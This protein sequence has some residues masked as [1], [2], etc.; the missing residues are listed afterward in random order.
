[1]NLY[2]S[3]TAKVFLVILALALSSLIFGISAADYYSYPQTSAAVR[4]INSSDG[5]ASLEEYKSKAKDLFA[6]LNRIVKENKSDPES[7]NELKT[8]LMS[9]VVPKQFMN[10]HVGLVLAADKLIDYSK[11]KD[12]KKLQQASII[13][14][15]AKK[16]YD[17]LN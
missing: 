12:D 14:T 7:V 5:T 11:S 6:T 1:M 13:I 15:Q 16:Q 4:K 3:H 9:L 10:L 8:Q 2:P 17:W